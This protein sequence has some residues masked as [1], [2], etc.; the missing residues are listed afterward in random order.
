MKES[1]GGTFNLTLLFF[2]ILLVS[3][4]AL[5]ATNYYRAFN[6]KNNITTL[7]EKYEGNF[8]NTK[9]KDKRRD[10][11]NQMSYNIDSVQVAKAQKS[12]WNCPDGEWNCPDGEGWCYC[13]YSTRTAGK[14]NN[15]QYYY[16]TYKIKTFVSTD[17]PVIN[18]IFLNT[19]F[20]EVDG[21]T[22]PILRS[23]GC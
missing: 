4:F 23:G 21:L 13:T 18:K 6:V 2:F 15:K 11:I 10:L 9:F 22:K 3:G 20:F 16:C 14:R 5:F 8:N 19:S 17:I 1:L 7:V 12:K